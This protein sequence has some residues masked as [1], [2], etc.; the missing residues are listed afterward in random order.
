MSA[1]DVSDVATTGLN[2]MFG[3]YALDKTTKLIKQTIPKGSN[4]PYKNISTKPR[5]MPKQSK[6]K[7][8]SWEWD[9]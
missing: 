6:H 4:K 2:V 5:K 9:F 3:I 7:G 8:N 1:S